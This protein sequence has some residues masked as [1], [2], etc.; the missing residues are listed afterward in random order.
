[1]LRP[2]GNKVLVRPLETKSDSIIELVHDTPPVAG[3]VVAVGKPR[4]RECDGDVPAQ[5]E[6]GQVV[7]FPAT[8]GME[9][10]M[11]G[12]AFYIVRL[13]DIEASWQHPTVFHEEMTR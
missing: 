12:D 6:V 3:E 13:E 11:D 5:I 10:T 2:V 1:M 8:A 9:V 7:L 4:C